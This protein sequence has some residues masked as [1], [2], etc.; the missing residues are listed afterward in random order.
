MGDRIDRGGL[1]SNIQCEWPVESQRV[2][3]K[4]LQLAPESFVRALQAAIASKQC[5]LFGVLF[6]S[7]IAEDGTEIDVLKNRSEGWRTVHFRLTPIGT[8]GILSLN[9]LR[10]EANTESWNATNLTATNS[11]LTSR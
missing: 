4:I 8:G 9:T 5:Y 10:L 3:L 6:V 1:C 7:E 2:T 11:E